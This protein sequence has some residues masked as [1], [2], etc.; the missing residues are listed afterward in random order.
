MNIS[1]KIWISVAV[2]TALCAS[3]AA[4]TFALQPNDYPVEQSIST[5][6]QQATDALPSSSS[7]VNHTE[8]DRLV[9]VISREYDSESKCTVIT[10]EDGTQAYLADADVEADS[11]GGAAESIAPTVPNAA[12]NATAAE[13]Y[14]NGE[15][16]VEGHFMHIFSNGVG[17]IISNNVKDDSEFRVLGSDTPFK[18]EICYW[19]FEFLDGTK[20]YFLGYPDELFGLDLS[21]YGICSYVEGGTGKLCREVVDGGVIEVWR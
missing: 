13:K 2:C 19:V 9:P 21:N 7:T 16:D 17:Y 11:A 18:D 3:G 5:E 20:R 4:T 12:D 6:P 14:G 1:K 10:Y 15:C 8:N